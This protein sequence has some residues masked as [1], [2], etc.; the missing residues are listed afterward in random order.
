[1]T[2]EEI[3]SSVA[4]RRQVSFAVSVAIAGLAITLLCLV[5]LIFRD[6]NA[7]SLF[8]DQLQENFFFDIFGWV[9]G[10]WLWC[11]V[12]GLC[13]WRHMS[14][15]GQWFGIVLLSLDQVVLIGIW[16]GV[17]TNPSLLTDGIVLAPLLLQ[18]YFL[19][20]FLGFFTM[21]ALTLSGNRRLTGLGTLAV[22]LP[23]L[24]G[25]EAII[26]GSQLL[27]GAFSRG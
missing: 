11:W 8:P 7:R 25:R 10:C 17:S 12:C 6:G 21:P 23:W 5:P 9:G 14:R 3:S 19:G 27:C 16:K 1:L 24:L 18:F 4:G 15:V 26:L 2:G 13:D 22:L 20:Y